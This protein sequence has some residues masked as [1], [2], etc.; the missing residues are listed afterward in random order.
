MIDGGARPTRDVRRSLPRGPSPGRPSR[1]AAVWLGGAAL[2]LGGLVLMVE[3]ASR[4]PVPRAPDLA[5]DPRTASLT[6]GPRGDVAPPLPAPRPAAPAPRVPFAADPETEEDDEIDAQPDP[7]QAYSDVD[8][9]PLVPKEIVVEGELAPRV[10]VSMDPLVP[11]V[12]EIRA[13]LA[14][15]R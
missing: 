5:P 6:E 10:P 13:E 15:R 1:A 9:A 11:R 2:V 14:P 7:A 3:A 4:G 8:Y 12:V